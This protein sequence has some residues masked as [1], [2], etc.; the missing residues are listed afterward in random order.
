MNTA[1]RIALGVCWTIIVAV[2]I[3]LNIPAG[4]V[5]LLGPITLAFF[6]WVEIK[7]AV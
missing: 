1:R 6:C 7:S 3:I 2:L 5:V 4:L